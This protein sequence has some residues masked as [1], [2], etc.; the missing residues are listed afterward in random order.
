MNIISGDETGLLKRVTLQR[1]PDIKVWGLRQDRALG[2]EALCWAGV[3]AWAERSVHNLTDCVVKGFESQFAV[4]R[5]NG[6]VEIRNGMSGDII[7]KFDGVAGEVAGLGVSGTIPGFATRQVVHCAATGDITVAETYEESLITPKIRTFKVRGPVEK[8]RLESTGQ[9]EFAVGGKDNIV[10]LWSLCTSKRLWNG[11]NVPHDH[12]DL[13]VPVWVTDIQF[14]KPHGRNKIGALQHQLLTC[15]SHRHLRLYDCR[16]QRRPVRSVAFGDCA[17][18]SL[19]VAPDQK[20]FIVADKKGTIEHIDISTF[21]RIGR[22]KGCGG[23]VRALSCHPNKEMI[24]SVGLDRWLRVHDMN[25]R[26][27]QHKVYMKQRCNALLFSAQCEENEDEESSDEEEVTGIEGKDRRERKEENMWASL[28]RR[29]REL[30]AKFESERKAKRLELEA[31]FEKQLGEARDKREKAKEVPFN[32]KISGDGLLEPKL[33][34]GTLEFLPSGKVA[35]HYI[36]QKPDGSW[37]NQCIFKG[38]CKFGHSSKSKQY[39]GRIEVKTMGHRDGRTTVLSTLSGSLYPQKGRG[40]LTGVNAAGVERVWTITFSEKAFAYLGN[41]EGSKNIM[42]ED[43]EEDESSE[44]EFEDSD[45]DD[46]E[47]DS[48]EENSDVTDEENE[49]EE[50]ESDEEEEEEGKGEISKRK[51]TSENVRSQKRIRHN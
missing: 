9:T 36:V 4:A 8:F 22:F 44:S 17:W 40:K 12:L 28:D 1:K 2:V 7:H 18:K 29:T 24:A 38:K 34:K 10:S 27:C 32:A 6:A 31:E 26:R 21:K 11:K 25:N 14:L 46:E 41:H 47:E 13:P 35:G 43:E 20:S 37:Y 48:E 51:I 30:R 15:S 19:A 33:S 3:P 50:S 5:R 16:A 49:G 42:V 39:R 45:D 23:S